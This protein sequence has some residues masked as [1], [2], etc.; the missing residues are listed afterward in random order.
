MISVLS[1][2]NHHILVNS[3]NN[4]YALSVDSESGVLDLEEASSV[5]TIKKFINN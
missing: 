5:I 1:M 2:N 3:Y 4:N